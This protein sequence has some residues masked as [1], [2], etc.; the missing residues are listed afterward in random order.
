MRRFRLIQISERLLE[1]KKNL[2]GQHIS[3]DPLSNSTCCDNFILPHP[4]HSIVDIGVEVEAN[5]KVFL[6]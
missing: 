1:T 6:L 5:P 4:N 2:E 3:L